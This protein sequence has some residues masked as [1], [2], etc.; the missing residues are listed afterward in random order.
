M[1]KTFT[2][3]RTI[4]GKIVLSFATLVLV[5]LALSVTS[6]FNVK[7]FNNEITNL[8]ERDLVVHTEIQKL[9]KSFVDI[10]TGERGF[11]ITGSES[12]LASYG[13][14]K[15]AVDNQLNLL[16]DF[17]KG[18][19][20]QEN[21]LANIR[22]TYNEWLKWIDSVIQA[23]RDLGKDEAAKMVETSEGRK[24]MNELQAH[25][26]NF[27]NEEKQNT[28]NRIDKLNQFVTIAETG[29]IVLSAAALL[30]AIFFGFTLSRNI[31]RSTRKI[32]QS[33]LEIANAGGDLT[34]RIHVKSKDELAGLAADTNTLIEGIAGLVK[35]VSLLAENVSA[36]SQELFASAEETSKTIAS[37]AV[38]TN[39]VAAGSD[40]TTSQMAVSDEKMKH[41]NQTATQLHKY[42]S[43]VQMASNEMKMAANVG[44]EYIELS[45]Q[46]MKTIEKTIAENTV[47]IEALGEKSS[48]INHMINTI[49]DIANQTNLLALNAAI[50]AARAGEH[51]KGFAVVADEVRKLAEGSQNAA[52]EVTNIVTMIHEEIEK[53]ILKNSNGVEEV[54]AGVKTMN[55]TSQSLNQ[56]IFN[57]NDTASVIST[58]GEQINQ[59][60]E[61]SNDVSASFKEVTSI[62]ALT[63]SNT[64]STA[65]A[66][67]EGTAAMEQVTASAAELSKQSEQLREV[68]G[69]FK[70]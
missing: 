14:G 28:E 49:T 35:Q 56:I 10:E 5:L 1:K 58:M 41:L 4:R 45:G 46:K 53:I 64:E 54:Q 51:G 66:A 50:E 48:E 26:D 62:A 22:S 59:V 15:N 16:K 69:N 70:F 67:E 42:A 8:V 24:L 36:S 61:L 27:V 13:N 23:R 63:A 37:I 29:T 40:H 31:R 11:V 3:F 18:D 39:E 65:A 44:S 20:K 30:L 47:L 6:F 7:M 2:Y 12:L 25:V 19:K 9:M 38:T 17:T 55:D 33:I 57:I 32:S 34:K 52:K 43:T 60:L 21:E 68:V